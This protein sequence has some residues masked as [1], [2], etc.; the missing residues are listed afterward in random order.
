[1]KKSIILALVLIAAV[2]MV[3]AGGSKESES[4]LPENGII[5]IGYVENLTGKSSNSGSLEKRGVDIAHELNH[6][7]EIDGKKYQIE[8]CVADAKSDKVESANCATRVIESDKVCAIIG[9]SNSGTNMAIAE[10][11]REAEVPTIASTATNPLVTAGNPYYFTACF[12][13]NVHA[14]AMAEFAYNKG[15]RKIAVVKE[16]TTDAAVDCAN[17][18]EENFKKLTGDPNCIVCE[19]GY[20][21]DDQDYNAQIV[22][23][24]QHKFD[25]IFAPNTAANLALMIKQADT[26]GLNTIWLG[27]DSCEVAQF[28]EIGGKA[29]VNKVFFTSFFDN[30]ISQTS[31]TD[32]LFAEYAKRYNDTIAAHTAMAFDAY[33]VLVEGIK[34]AKST[35]GADIVK[36]LEGL[37]NYPAASGYMT[38]NA[39][40]N[41]ENHAVIKTVD[42]N[43]KFSF[44]E[45]WVEK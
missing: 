23:L 11:V 28:I 10:I 17:R 33:N 7:I 5:K 18:F 39:A 44:V 14:V 41:V 29:L 9:P 26:M 43:L 15:Y 16:I 36:A 6:E 27:I 45:N 34:Q 38:F 24:K 21:V 22:T 30:Q 2:S 19:V 12:T 3:F 40:H 4:K 42:K 35:K 20:N 31:V 37:K 1:M 13:N 25:A 8:L 32:T